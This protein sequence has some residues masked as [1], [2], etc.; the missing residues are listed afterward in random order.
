M[1]RIVLIVSLMAGILLAS[2]GGEEKQ[3]G[4]LDPSSSNV[5]VVNGP[6]ENESGDLS[7]NWNGD[8]VQ[9]E[10]EDIYFFMQ[11]H[12][13][14]AKQLG[15]GVF[16]E[17]LEEGSGPLVQSG[18]EV[19]L[20]YVTQAL[21]GD[22]VYTSQKSGLKNF[23]VDKSEEI[24]GLHEAVKSLRKGARAHI[25][26]PSWRAYGVGGD[27]DCIRGKMSL[28]MTVKVADVQSINAE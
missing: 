13:W 25:L 28:A 8:N 1:E 2:C 21:T 27:G 23:R 18:D 17:I 15:S 16:V 12:H 5:A 24:S 4:F 26:V 11:R 7:M 9:R 3:Q 14:N 19:S 10:K 22:T 20:E 6:T